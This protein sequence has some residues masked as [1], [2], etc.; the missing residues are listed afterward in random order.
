MTERPIILQPWEVR[1]VLAGI[2]M[3]AR[4]VIVPQPSDCGLVWIDEKD[5]G[6][7]AWQDNGVNFGE[8]IPVH[9]LCPFGGVGDILWVRETFAVGYNDYHWDLGWEGI[10]M[11]PDK[12]GH[13]RPEDTQWRRFW[14]V[15]AADKKWEMCEGE[16]WRPAIHMPRWASR[17]ALRVTEIRAERVQDI[18][19]SDAREEGIAPR[20]VDTEFLRITGI[21]MQAP[22]FRKPFS[23]AWDAA[24]SKRGYSFDANPFCWV[25]KFEV[26]P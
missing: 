18:T 16:C 11:W 5:T 26:M 21:P 22:S 23:L 9:R 8:E 7:A 17:I 6:F 25:I 2:K 14:T 10:G 1:A 3:Q 15:Y 24:Y 4:R 20:M 12:L 13:D 19:S